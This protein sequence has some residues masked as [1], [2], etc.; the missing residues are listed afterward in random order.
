[1]TS[2]PH[3]EASPSATRGAPRK[4][5]SEFFAGIGLVRLALEKTGW[6]CVYANDI[7]PKKAEQYAAQ[8]GND[9]HFHLGDVRDTDCVTSR[10]AEGT[11]LATASF[12]CIDL[13]LAQH[14][15]G[16][17]GEHSSTFF[18]FAKAYAFMN[19]ARNLLWALLCQGILNDD[20]LEWY[21][22]EYG[23]S[24]VVE[25]N[26][27]EWLTG[28]AASRARLVIG[29]V[30]KLEPYVANMKEENYRFLRTQAVFKKCMEVAYNRWG[31][32]H[33]RLK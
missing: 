21:S 5:F 17:E 4:T 15:R 20:E 23:Q 12:P 9:R 22:K 1:M 25:A 3:A 19:P 29:E 27:A 16:L 33:K 7:D 26:Y 6:Q 14:W 31:W 24:L 10:M 28:L 11:V 13:S 18:G 2:A 30:I 8:F 32:L